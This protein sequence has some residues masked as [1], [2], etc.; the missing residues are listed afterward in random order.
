MSSQPQEL[1][2]DEKTELGELGLRL[3]RIASGAG[4]VLLIVSVILGFVEGDSLR[5]FFYSYLASFGFYLSIALG[6]LFFV[7]L[8]HLTRSTW[9]VVVRRLAENLTGTLPALAALFLVI[10]LPMLFGNQELYFWTTAEAAHDHFVHAKQG[11]L[12]VPFFAVRA[13]VY[14]AVWILIARHFASKSAEQDRSGDAALSDRLRVLS[15][16]AMIAFA[17]TTAFAAFDLLMSLHPAWYS[18]MFGVYYFAGAGIAIFAVLGIVS[19]AVQKSGRLTHSITV[20]HYHDIGKLLFAFVFFWGY[21]AFSQFMLIWYANIPEETIWY[22]YRMFTSWKWASVALLAGHFAFPFLCLLS[23]A[24][25]RHMAPFLFFCVWMLVMHFVDIFWLVMPEF[26]QSGASF[27]L[28]DVT[29]VLGIGGIFVAAAARAAQGRKLIP[30]K[31]PKLAESLGFE[32][33]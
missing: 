12:N 25:K 20:E 6:A 1:H 15:A 2:P 30:V 9:S 19:W 14:F 5:R 21:I 27:K 10:L 31:D 4:L 17:F 24:T 13:I 32:N 28:M 16:P 26:D 22:K 23:R 18:T 7:L 33:Y 3:V 11:Y 29:L 8:Q